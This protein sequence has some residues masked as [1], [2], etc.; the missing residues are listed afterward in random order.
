MNIY[1]SMNSIPELRGYPKAQQKTLW[2]RA[3]KEN[4]KNKLVWLGYG[5]LFLTIFGASM[6][7]PAAS[8]MLVGILIGGAI[9]GIAGLISSQLIIAAIRPT[10][11]RYRHELEQTS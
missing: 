7:I 10:L 2:R 4:A 8:S 9:G 3:L 6:L 11:A 1:L 5:L